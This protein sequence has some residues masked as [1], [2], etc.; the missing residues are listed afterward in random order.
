MSNFFFSSSITDR[1]YEGSITPVAST[2]L[3][4]WGP[5]EFCPERSFAKGFSLKV[6]KSICTAIVSLL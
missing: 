6:L 5:A 1:G 3:G 2:N 4:E